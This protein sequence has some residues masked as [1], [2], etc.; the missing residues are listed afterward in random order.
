MWF[1]ITTIGDKLVLVGGKHRDYSDSSELGEWEPDSN[2]WTHP[3]PSMSTPRFW[4]SATSYKNWLVV[5]CGCSH[6]VCLQTVEVLD[7]FNMQWSTGS[8]IPTLRI[9]IRSTTIA[10]IWYLIGGW[11]ENV[12]YCLDVC[13]LPLEALVTHSS[14]DN[15]YIWNKLPSLESTHSCPLNIG[16]SLLA[17][18]GWD[19]KSEKPMSTIQRYVPETNTWV[20]AGQLPHAVCECTCIM[21]SHM[22]LVWEDTMEIADKINYCLPKYTKV[23][24]FYIF[25][26]FEQ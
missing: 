1:A 23:T 6:K 20:E 13:S 16:G 12:G 3:F 5:A 22:I 15:S 19:P 4:P 17:V 21:T 10:D 14:S 2:K 25:L 24:I 8:P 7:V 9:R 18:G 11:C 26:E